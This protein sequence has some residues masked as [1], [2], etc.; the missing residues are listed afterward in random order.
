MVGLVDSYP[1]TFAAVVVSGSASRRSTRG[2]ALRQLREPRA[3]RARH[4]HL[5]AR[6]QRGLRARAAARDAGR[7]RVRAA[8][9]AAGADPALARR[10][11]L[12]L[13]ELGRLRE[14]RRRRRRADG[15]QAMEAGRDEWGPFARLAS[16]VGLRSAVFFGLQAFVPIYFAVELG[17]AR[18]PAT[19]R[20][21]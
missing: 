17:R 15:A 1:A 16:V 8:G 21:A 19:A 7:A 3:A 20:S 6:R 13:A 18:R 5:L 9:H 2:R 12:L 11:G 14:L 4:E 10:A